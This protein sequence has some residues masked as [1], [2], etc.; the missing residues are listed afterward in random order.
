MNVS[1][2]TLLTVAILGTLGLGVVKTVY[3]NQSKP[4][5]AVMLYPFN[6][7][8]AKGILLLVSCPV[9]VRPG[10]GNRGLDG[11]ESRTWLLCNRSHSS[12]S[13]WFSGDRL[14]TR[15]GL[16]V[17]ILDCLYHD[18]SNGCFNRGFPLSVTSKR[19]I[20]AR[21]NSHKCNISFSDPADSHLPFYHQ[22]GF[23][24]Q[25][26]NKCQNQNQ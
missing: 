1:T 3:A 22:A 4:L 7:Y 23:N 17:G 5:V 18:T 16:Y 20:G 24:S 11:R 10:D 25:S 19:W 6:F 26:I 13:N 21:C 9:H 14:E 12:R 8:L 2:K 15:L